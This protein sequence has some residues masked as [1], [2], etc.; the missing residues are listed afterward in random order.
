MTIVTEPA[1]EPW[2]TFIPVA[3][4]S[5]FAFLSVC[6][7]KAYSLAGDGVHGERIV[8]MNRQQRSTQP[9]GVRKGSEGLVGRGWKLKTH[10]RT[11]LSHHE[12]K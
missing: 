1:G 7:K 11:D 9:L 6:L 10:P 3:S 5:Q 2:A 12:I 8:G 4:S